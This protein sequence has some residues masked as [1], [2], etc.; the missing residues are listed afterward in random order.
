MYVWPSSLDW[1]TVYIVSSRAVRLYRKTMSNTH[2]HTHNHKLVST[3]RMTRIPLDT[4]HGSS[5]P[6]SRQREPCEVLKKIDIHEDRKSNAKAQK[7]QGQ[8][9]P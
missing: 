8:R 4:K 9:E 5:H 2:T 3:Y 7:H 1:S 6:G